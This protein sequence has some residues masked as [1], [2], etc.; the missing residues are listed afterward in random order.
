[1]PA[2]GDTLERFGR[3]YIFVNPT[4]SI[5][6]LRGYVERD[7][8]QGTVGAWRLSVD[9]EYV[10]DGGG[11][12]GGGGG[13]PGTVGT[14]QLAPDETT[15][16]KGTLLYI[17]ASGFARRA[18]ADQLATSN[19]I[20]A[21]TTITAPGN[22]VT[23]KTNIVLDIFDTGAVVDND[24]GGVLATGFTYYLSA[25]NAGNWTI[26]PDTTTPGA[27]VIQCGVANDTNQMLVEIQP[28]TEV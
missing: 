1:M 4:P 18:Q 26:T 10:P 14:A 24:L 22:V 12:G 17:D 16:D 2:P 7:A 11:G 13:E 6:F 21:A 25:V 5:T 15:T 9:D 8:S 19:V 23:Y 20:G 28:A 27:V 3:S